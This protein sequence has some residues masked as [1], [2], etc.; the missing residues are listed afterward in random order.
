MVLV[1]GALTTAVGCDQLSGKSDDKDDKSS[2]DDS[3][4]KK[5]KKKKKKSDDEDD[6]DSDDKDAKASAD[7]PAP[8]VA[9]PPVAGDSTGIP[10][11]DKYIAQLVKCSPAMAGSVGQIKAGFK[12][13]ADNAAVRA[14]LIATCNQSFEQMKN[15]GAGAVAP[16]MPPMPVAPPS[17][18]APPP[19]IAPPAVAPPPT[20][21]GPRRTAG[22]STVPTLAE[23][24]AVTKE[25][26]VRGSSSLNC[27]TK[28][29]REW[30]RV[31]CRGK[32]NPG[33]APVSVQIL[34]GGGR[35]NAF[36]LSR[37]GEVTSLV[38]RF[39]PGTNLEAMFTWETRQQKF[40]SFWPRGA[41]EPQSK[42]VFE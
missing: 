36:V 23:W 5:K 32:I 21:T 2:D 15:C 11:C 7:S 19:A 25:V 20:T 14:Q 18:I 6:S 31:S 41:P 1:L 33:G 16:T 17:P 40:T 27:E 26:S 30:L 10:E 22:N 37:T 13:G 35:G 3:G 42:G 8:D 34:N 24:D 12:M 28:M 39:N 4:K 9:S 38:M 29:V